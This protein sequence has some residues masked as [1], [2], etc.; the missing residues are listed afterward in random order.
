DRHEHPRGAAQGGR[1]SE[2]RDLHHALITFPLK[3]PCM[4]PTVLPA[5]LTAATLLLGAAPS[6]DIAFNDNLTS[7]GRLSKGAL[8]VSLEIREGDWQVLGPGKTPGRVL[9]FAET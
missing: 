2:R 8:T 6:D 4:S 7:A 9:A 3:V 5:V 1:G